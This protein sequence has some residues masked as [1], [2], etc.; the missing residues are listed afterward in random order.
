[1]WLIELSL[2]Q[3]HVSRVAF[4]SK[5]HADTEL[6]ALKSKMGKDI[7]ERNKEQS[8]R[9]HTIKG[10]CEELVVVLQNLYAAC[11]VDPVEHINLQKSFEDVNL[12]SLRKRC[13]IKAEYGL[14]S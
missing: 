10:D 12:E 8:E 9:T 6:I 2:G 3:G 7:Y 1:M 5:E 13:A 4:T 11:V 14:K